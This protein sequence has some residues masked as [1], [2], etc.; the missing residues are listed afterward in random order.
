M[1]EITSLDYSQSQQGDTHLMRQPGTPY[2]IDEI[3]KLRLKS[4]IYIRMSTEL[5]VESPENQERQIRAYAER[6]GIEIIK[7]YA[8]LGVSGMT[9]EKR[10]QFQALLDDVDNGRNNYSIV[11]Y[12]DD[13]RWGRFVD[14]RDADY[15][16]M[17]LERNGVICQACDKPLTMTTTIADRIMTMLKDESASDYCRQLSQKVFIGQSNLILKGYRQGGPAGFGLRRM[18]LTETGEPKQELV[19]GQRKSLQ[20]ERVVLIP[21]PQSEQ[22]KVV[23]MYDQFIA[24]KRESEIADILNVEGWQTDFGR[25]WTRGTVREVL[26]NEK[27]IGNNLF[28]RRSG[29]LKSKQKKNPE[30]EWVRKDGAFP[31]VVD[32]ERFYAVQEFIQERHKKMTN[33]DLLER[34]TNLQRQTGRLSAMIIDESEEMPPSSLYMHRFGGL[35]RAYRLIGYI[36][37]RDY[38]YVEINQRL[39]TMHSD[40]VLQTV[41]DIERLCGRKISVD[42]ATNLL[43]L[44]YHLFISIVISRCFITPSGL[45]RWKIR[46]DTG[47]HPD[48]TVAV[49]M[50][51]V[52]EDIH[53]YYILPALEF[54]QTALKLQDEN[55][56]LLD[57][58]RADSLEYLLGMSVNISLD[59]AV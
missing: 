15:Y 45:R 3:K 58:F 56:D 38:R 57:S 23:W 2:T 44:N 17:S 51:A 47:L 13:S 39:R 26:T 40:I 21:G 43:E 16:R 19:M 12:L 41:A 35:L 33:E 34:L 49:R 32:L 27:Y 54:G 37:E 48:I 36:P 5:Q 46:F 52:N 50:N 8:D 6:Y 25:P 53:D 24:G 11:L 42:P 59:K 28:N 22:D 18:L 55:T 9:A 7:T 4:A 30:H 31:P 10:E 1:D 29:K 20:T 14:S